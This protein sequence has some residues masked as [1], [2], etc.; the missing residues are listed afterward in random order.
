MSSA[1]SVGRSG[2]YLLDSSILILSLRGDAAIRARLGA[3]S[4]LYIPSVA[5]GELYFGAH[6]S[7]TR[8]AAALSDVDALA[9]G[10]TILAVDTTTAQIYGRIRHE[11]KIKGLAMPANDLWIAA[12][13][14]QYGLTLAARDAHFDWIDGL[15]VEQCDEGRSLGELLPLR[16]ICLR[17]RRYARLTI[18]EADERRQDHE[19]W[20]PLANKQPI[21]A[22]ATQML[23]G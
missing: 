8:G 3:T 11:L 19:G 9:T 5:L 16:P 21:L 7:P 15:S 13:G 23:D 17:W 18:E 10:M 14:I 12:V 22:P 6:G 4:T 2:V 1:A 20:R